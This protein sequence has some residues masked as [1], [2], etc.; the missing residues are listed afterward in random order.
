MALVSR[1]GWLHLETSVC[2]AEQPRA[3]FEHLLRYCCCFD[4]WARVGDPNDFESLVRIIK[5]EREVVS[6]QVFSG[7]KGLSTR[8]KVQ[9]L[10]HP[11]RVT[12]KS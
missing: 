1:L 7:T 8:A 3:R 5:V 11:M 10:G 9:F 12:R 6:L 4:D 2:V